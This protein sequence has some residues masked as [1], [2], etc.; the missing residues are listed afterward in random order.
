MKG[1]RFASLV[2]QL[3]SRALQSM[4]RWLTQEH[5]L[6]NMCRQMIR[7]K[8]LADFIEAFWSDP[9]HR[10]AGTWTDHSDINTVM[11]ATS[12]SPDGYLGTSTLMI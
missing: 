11:L 9:R 12:L 7:Y 10:M 8:P 3:V 5:E 1:Y 6:A 4:N 2:L